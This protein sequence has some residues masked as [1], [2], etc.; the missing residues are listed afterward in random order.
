[1]AQLI[2]EIPDANLADV[3]DTLCVLWGYSATVPNPTYDP[4]QFLDAP[5]NLVLN[6]AYNPNATIANPQNK[7]QF[8]KAF[9]SKWIKESYKH[10]K[11]NQA[12]IDA[13]NASNITTSAIPIT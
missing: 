10:G 13:V 6:P 4:V 8:L 2:I 11:A 7:I 1:M 9:T 5:A 3:R 12:S